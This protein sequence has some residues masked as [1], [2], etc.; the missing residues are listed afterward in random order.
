MVLQDDTGKH[1]THAADTIGSNATL[2]KERMISVRL[3]ENE[4]M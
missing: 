4:G 3:T 2:D 1:D